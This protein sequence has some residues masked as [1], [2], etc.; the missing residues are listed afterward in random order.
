MNN[1]KIISDV[2]K[3]NIYCF[4]DLEEDDFIHITKLRLIDILREA[5]KQKDE[6]IENYKTAEPL[7]FVLIADIQ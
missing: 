6:E 3:N 4:E 5:Q 1:E 2:L 7:E